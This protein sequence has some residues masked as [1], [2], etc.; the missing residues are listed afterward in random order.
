MISVNHPN[1]IYSF[2]TLPN[3]LLSSDSPRPFM[4]LLRAAASSLALKPLWAFTVPL[5]A[6][7]TQNTAFSQAQP[8]D[9]QTCYTDNYKYN[10]RGI[11]TQNNTKYNKFKPW[12]Y[13][14][15]ANVHYIGPVLFCGH[16]S[17][18]LRAS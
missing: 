4:A 10:P 3:V 5:P 12:V 1:T 8:S 7:K 11:K 14:L 9:T 17:G 16:V 2:N 15:L 18:T 6:Y 13:M